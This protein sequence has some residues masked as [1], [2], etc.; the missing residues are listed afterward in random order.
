MNSLSR[1]N[2]FHSAKQH[3]ENYEDFV[4]VWADG[5]VMNTTDNKNAFRNLREI[6]NRL[7]TFNREKECIDYVHSV[8]SEKVFLI[9]SGALGQNIVPQLQSLRQLASVYVFCANRARHEQWA[10]QIKIV[11]GVYTNIAPICEQLRKETTINNNDQLGIQVTDSTLLLKNEVGYQEQA[12]FMYAQFLKEILLAFEATEESKQEMINFCRSVYSDNSAELC[13]INEFATD[14]VKE[15]AVRWYSRSCFLYRLLNKALRVQDTDVLYKL[16]YYVR[17][18]HEALDQQYGQWRIEQ[19]VIKLLTVYRGLNMGLDEFEKLKNKAGGFL[20]VTSFMSTTMDKDV[21]LVFTGTNT[22]EK[23]RVLLEIKVDIGSCITPFVDIH[24]QSYFPTEAEWLFSM[25]TV[26]R[27]ISVVMNDTG[28]WIVKVELTTEENPELKALSAHIRKDIMVPNPLISLLN[29]MVTMGNYEKAISFCLSILQRSRVT[30]NFRELGHLYKSLGYCCDKTGDK[31]NAICFYETALETFLQHLSE[32]DPTL[33]DIYTKLSD[34]YR[35]T[36]EYGKVLDFAIKALNIALA[37][38]QPD[39]SAIIASYSS[40]GQL[41]RMEKR[42]EEAL[43]MYGKVLERQM[44]LLPADHPDIAQTYND[45]SQVYDSQC[46]WDKCIEYLKKSL[47]IRVRSLPPNHPSLAVTY[48]NLSF[49]FFAQKKLKEAV[50]NARIAYK[51]SSTA[52]PDGNRDAHEDFKWLVEVTG[53]YKRA[54]EQ[55]D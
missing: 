7:E 39:Q 29:L 25:G 15:K 26:F 45:I 18:L 16:R 24:E 5:N 44:N 37:N 48:H 36:G 1:D 30:E 54:G 31:S 49:A 10:N 40:I 51:I 50:E 8:N 19:P 28:L 22:A 14:Y 3:G 43:D 33:S 20:L 34:V 4:V 41:C 13:V 2:E 42:Y 38:A 55:H 35:S 53:Y 46:I 32:T 52:L 12:F 27:V 6:V 17:H 9:V 11:R 47:E 23:T 21:A